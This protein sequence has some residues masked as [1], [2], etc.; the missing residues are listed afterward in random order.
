MF[1]HLAWITSLAL[2]ERNVSYSIK[3]VCECCVTFSFSSFFR[4]RSRALHE[5]ELAIAA[6]DDDIVVERTHVHVVL[7]S[8]YERVE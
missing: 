2:T 1:G 5:R 6:T 7:R 8:M 3:L 4:V